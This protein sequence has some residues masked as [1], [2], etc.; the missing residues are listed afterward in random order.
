MTPFFVSLSLQIWSCKVITCG[1]CNTRFHLDGEANTIYTFCIEQ[2][3][4]AHTVRSTPVFSFM[5]LLYLI[6]CSCSQVCIGGETLKSHGICYLLL[7]PS[8]AP[9]CFFKLWDRIHNRVWYRLPGKF[10]YKLCDILI[11]Y[12]CYE[13]FFFFLTKSWLHK[14]SNMCES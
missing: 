12:V 14:N 10:P 4:C 6:Y 1:S 13:V 5:Q 3:R 11:N 7:S 8:I 9:I 2:H